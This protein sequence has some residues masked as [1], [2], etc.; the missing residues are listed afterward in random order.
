MSVTRC[1]DQGD[2]AHKVVFGLH[3][4][5]GVRG[6]KREIEIDENTTFMFWCVDSAQKDVLDRYIAV[7]NAD[8]FF[9]KSLMGY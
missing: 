6:S 1:G 7:K 5:V 9:G 8:V 3:C 4:R 2:Q